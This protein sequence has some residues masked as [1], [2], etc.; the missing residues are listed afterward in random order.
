M[1]KHSSRQFGDYF[2]DL[3]AKEKN[4]VAFAL[5]LGTI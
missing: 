4:I 2:Q 3:V 5:V 1:M